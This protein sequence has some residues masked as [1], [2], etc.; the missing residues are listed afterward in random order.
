RCYTWNPTVK[1]TVF[2]VSDR[3]APHVVQETTLDGY[4]QD[5]RAIGDTVYVAVNNYMTY[6]PAPE[7]TTEGD[8]YVYETEASYRARLEALPFD[9]LLP[10]YTTEWKDGQ[11]DHSESGLLNRGGDIYRPEVADDSNILSIVAFNVKGRPGP[12]DSISMLTAGWTTLY[13]AQ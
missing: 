4:Y 6:L 3:H 12:V 10:H 8:S 2:D 9:S 1:V 13:A 7:Y 11:G 5:S